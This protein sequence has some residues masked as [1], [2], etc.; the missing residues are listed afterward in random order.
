MNIFS[1]FVPKKSVSLTKGLS[2][3]TP[4]NIEDDRAEKI[5]KEYE[6]SKETFLEKIQDKIKFFWIL[7]E[8]C[9]N[10]CESRIEHEETKKQLQKMYETSGKAEFLSMC[11]RINNENCIC[12]Y[13]MKLQRTIQELFILYK[14]D[15]QKNTDEQKPEVLAEEEKFYKDTGTTI[16]KIKRGGN[17]RSTKQKNKNKKRRSKTSKNRLQ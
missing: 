13:A 4:L 10:D 5:Q 14:T 16:Q 3:T 6:I 15:P 17:R 8:L 7:T 2:I 12:N 11:G 9:K 1:K